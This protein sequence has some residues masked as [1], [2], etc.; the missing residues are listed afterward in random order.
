MSEDPVRSL[1]ECKESGRNDRTTPFIWWGNR[2]CDADGSML[3]RVANKA[4]WEATL[5]KYA[6]IGCSRPRGQVELYGIT[7]H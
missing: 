5:A 7:E 1:Q 4:A 3:S 6:D 2:Y